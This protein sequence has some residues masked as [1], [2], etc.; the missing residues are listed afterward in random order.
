VSDPSPENQKK[1][2]YTMDHFGRLNEWLE[3]DSTAAR[4]QFNSLTPNDFNTFSNQ[5]RKAGSAGLASQLDV[6]L[7]KGL[8]K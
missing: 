2:E 6:A 5:L 3:C 7:R 8:E 4:Y 1:Y